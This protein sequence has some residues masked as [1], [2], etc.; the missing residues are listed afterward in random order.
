MSPVGFPEVPERLKPEN[1][2]KLAT[3]FVKQ[4]GYQTY[5]KMWNDWNIAPFDPLR[6][7]GGWLSY[8]MI[9]ASLNR[10]MNNMAPEMIEKLGL[11]V[12]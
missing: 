4:T 12:H 8:K 2:Q 7:M 6:M 3:S 10:R 5:L 11:Y 1:L 9:K